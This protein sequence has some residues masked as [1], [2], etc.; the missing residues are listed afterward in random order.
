MS[1]YLSYVALVSRNFSRCNFIRALNPKELEFA[2][3]TLFRVVRRRLTVRKSGGKSLTSF[4]RFTTHSVAP[5]RLRTA[6]PPEPPCT[7]FPAPVSN[8]DRPPIRT[9]FLV[10]LNILDTHCA[11]I[12]LPVHLVIC[13]RVSGCNRLESMSFKLAYLTTE[14]SKT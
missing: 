10:F 4:N 3:Y 9:A 5:L 11:V 2:R 7:Y 1:S 12:I 6:C 14:T 13:I 8:N